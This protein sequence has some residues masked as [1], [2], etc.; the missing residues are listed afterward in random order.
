MKKSKQ[1]ISLLLAG[2][3]LGA[4][5]AQA[6]SP[7]LAEERLRK[8]L[9]EEGT[10]LAAEATT[11][12]RA[13][14]SSMPRLTIAPIQT[15]EPVQAAG[16]VATPSD[17]ILAAVPSP[18]AS[19]N[20]ETVSADAPKEDASTGPDRETEDLETTPAVIP[21][22][23]VS[24]KQDQETEEVETTPAVTPTEDVSTEPDQEAGAEE[25]TPVTPPPA[26]SMPPAESGEEDETTPAPTSSPE[27]TTT[28]T[29]SPDGEEGGAVPVP[30]PTETADVEP[31]P[32]ASGEVTDI[33]ALPEEEQGELMAPPMAVMSLDAE[34]E[35]RME[36]A[37]IGF[38]YEVY[39]ADK[40]NADGSPKKASTWQ[41]G[42][43]ELAVEKETEIDRGYLHQ[44]S[45]M[46]KNP[47]DG[48]DVKTYWALGDNGKY[49]Y[50]DAY[51]FYD[52]Q[53]TN[54]REVAENWLGRIPDY[55]F[56]SWYISGWAPLGNFE[57]FYLMDN[58]RVTWGYPIENKSIM[59][60]LSY[61]SWEGNP[62]YRL[63]PDG[64]SP[65]DMEKAKGT[66]VHD[67]PRQDEL[68][69][70]LDEQV[71]NN[72]SKYYYSNWWPSG[73][74]IYAI[75]IIA[76]WKL[77]DD[78]TLVDKAFVNGDSDDQKYTENTGLFTVGLDGGTTSTNLLASTL[79]TG[80][81]GEEGTG[82]TSLDYENGG[83]YYL[84][85]NS[86]VAGVDPVLLAT[87]AFRSQ[88]IE[89]GGVTIKA[90]QAG[91]SEYVDYT[92]DKDIL[93]DSRMENGKVTLYN[94][95]QYPM[96][97]KWTLGDEV[98]YI[99]L[100]RS[101]AGAEDKTTNYYNEIVVTVTAPD[102]ISTRTY[103]FFIQRLNDPWVAQ[104]PGNTPYGMIARDDVTDSN[105][106][107]NN[108]SLGLNAQEAKEEAR[109]RFKN[110]Y[111]G[112]KPYSFDEEKTNTFF[113]SD[114]VENNHSAYD[115]SLVYD[116][117]A[118]AGD[119]VD[120]DE[121]AIVVY[122][123]SSFVD[124]GFTIYDSQGEK[125]TIDPTDE[126]VK[127]SVVLRVSN[128]ASGGISLKE[129]KDDG[130]K[131]G[132]YVAGTK[133][134][135]TD[136]SDETTGVAFQIVQDA[137]GKDRI[138]LRGAQ[139][140]P[141]VYEIRYQFTDP[142][143]EWTY[144]ST[145]A[146]KFV[147]SEANNAATF[148]RTL[149]VLPILGDV[150]M[151]GA[152]TAADA[153]VLQRAINYNSG[154]SSVHDINF[155]NP[156]N[157]KVVDLFRLR[158]CDVNNDG[159]VDQ[160]D[161][162]MIRGADGGC[163]PLFV[164][165]SRCDDYFYIPLKTGLTEAEE[166][167][168][169]VRPEFSMGP[170]DAS[171]G[172]IE[173]EFLGLHTDEIT[174]DPTKLNNISAAGVSLQ[175]GD[176]F[177][178][179]VKVSDLENLPGGE[180]G[181]EKAAI[182]GGIASISLSIAYDSR[183]VE[184]AALSEEGDDIY[185]Q[186]INTVSRYNI[187]DDT[188]NT[189]M[190]YWPTYY[191]V[192]QAG[193]QMGQTY[194]THYSKTKIPGEAD[195]DRYIRQMTVAFRSG[196]NTF[197]VLYDTKAGASGD[198]YLLRVPFRLIEAPFEAEKL[199]ALELGLGMQDFNLFS[200]LI[201]ED[202]TLPQTSAAWSQ[203]S[204]GI[205]GGGTWN[206]AEEL[207][208][209]DGSARAIPLAPDTGEKTELVNQT[210]DGKTVYG[211]PYTYRNNDLR[212]Q[213]ADRIKIPKG[214]TYN[215]NDGLISGT[216]EE[217]GRFVFQVEGG[218]NNR[219]TCVI[220][221]EK[222]PLTLTAVGQTRYYGEPNGELDYQ[223]NTLE[224][225]ALD[226]QGGKNYDTVKNFQNNG[227]S[228]E[229]AK[230][231]GYVKPQLTTDAVQGS[232]VGTYSITVADAGNSGLDNYYFVYANGTLDENGKTVADTAT[233]ETSAASPLVVEKRPLMIEKLNDSAM[234]TVTV[235][236]DQPR[237]GFEGVAA[238][239]QEG[240]KQDFAPADLSVTAEYA[241]R[242]TGTPVY[243]KEEVTIS[244]TATLPEWDHNVPPYYDI[245]GA[246]AT[247]EA[248]ISDVVLTETVFNRNYQLIGLQTTT[249]NA[250]VKAN[251]VVKIEVEEPPKMVYTYNDKISFSLMTV[252]LT[253]DDG[254]KSR[255]VYSESSFADNGI[256]V[257]WVTSEEK[258]D[259]EAHRDEADRKVSDKDPMFASIHDGK[260]LCI[261]VKGYKD[262]KSSDITWYS[263]EAFKV[264]K[265][266]LTL[267]VKPLTVYYGE[268]E[269][270]ML[271]FTYNPAQLAPADYEA[272]KTALG[273][274]PDG[275]TSKELEVLTEYVAPVLTAWTGA[276]DVAGAKKVTRDTGVLWSG[277]SVRSY[278]IYIENKKD[279]DGKILSGTP[280]YSFRYVQGSVETT[281][282]GLG[283]LTI[284]PR[285]IV[286]NSVTLGEDS[287]AFLY[288]DTCNTVLKEM[289]YTDAE[290]GAYKAQ[291]VTLGGENPGADMADTFIAKQPEGGTYFIA[292]ETG[293]TPVLSSGL[294][295]D[296]IYTG[297][298]GKKDRVVVTYEA[299]YTRDN[300]SAAPPSTTYFDMNGQAAK[301]TN[302]TVRNLKLLPGEGDNANYVL[303]F[304]R[305]TD[306]TSS[307]PKENTALGLVK[308]R[309]ME[310]VSV[311][312]DPS[313]SGDYIYGQQLNLSGMTLA[314][315]YVQEGDN[316][317][318]ENR[319]VINRT[320]RYQDYGDG[321]DSFGLQGLMVYWLIDDDL[322]IPEDVTAKQLK[323]YLTDGKLE[324]VSLR[325][326]YPDVAKSGKK[327]VV[328]G[329]RYNGE[330]ARDVGH[331]LVW[332]AVSDSWNFQMKKK[333]LLL[334]VEEKNRFYGEA[335]GTF[336]ASY[337]FSA[338]AAP[339]QKALTD[340]SIAADAKGRLYVTAALD[341]AA[342]VPG[343]GSDAK[344]VSTFAT[345]LALEEL[346]KPYA[347]TTNLGVRFVTM[348]TQAK[349]VGTYTI[350]CKLSQETNLAN[351]DFAV[352]PAKLRVFRRPIV[353]NKICQQPVSNIYENT[354]ETQFPAYVEQKGQA[355]SSSGTTGFHTILP[356][357]NNG[358]YESDDPQVVAA[359]NSGM[360]HAM[361]LSGKAIYGEDTV[362]LNMTVVFPEVGSR[363]PNYNGGF[364]ALI[365]V[366]IKNLTLNGE[367]EKNY[368]LVYQ[369]NTD[370]SFNREPVDN[371]AQGQLDM[372]PITKI[373]VIQ[374]PKME[375]VYGEPL[376]LSGLKVRVTYRELE[377]LK[378]S[379]AL[380]EDLSYSELVGRLAVNYW[381]SPT[382]PG[383]ADLPIAK[384]PA[385]SGNHL[386][387]A[388]SH[389]D[390][391]LSHNGKYLVLYARTDESMGY[392]ADAVM[393]C[394]TT[395]SK[396]PPVQIKVEPL[397][398]TYTLQAEDKTYAQDGYASLT[399]A[400][401]S[402][403]LTNPYTATK[404]VTDAGGGTTTENDRDLI[405]V[406]T[407]V[408]YTDEELK[409][410]LNGKAN[411]GEAYTFSADGAPGAAGLTFNFYD[412]NVVY[413]DDTYTKNTPMAAKDWAAYWNSVSHEAK[414]SGSE[415]W[416]SYGDVAPMP[417][418][419]SGIQLAGPDKANYKLDSQVG[420][421][422]NADAAGGKDSVPFAAI[423]K[424]ARPVDQLTAAPQVS[425]DAH[426]NAVQ[427]TYDIGIGMVQ[428]AYAGDRYNSELHYEYGLESWDSTP[429]APGDPVQ[430]MQQWEDWSDLPYY[431]GEKMEADVPAGYEPTE[432]NPSSG[433]REELKGQAYPWEE[434]DTAFGTRTPLK[435][436]T[437]YWGMIRLAE[438][439]NYLA[440]EAVHAVRD[441]AGETAAA[442][443]AAAEM[444]ELVQSWVETKP[445]KDSDAPLLGPATA[446][447]TYKQ[448]FKLLSTE[449][450]TG[451]DN[452]K[453]PVDTLEAVWF[454]DLQKY[455]DEKLLDAVLRN[456]VT[457][458][459]YGYYWDQEQ[460]AELE[461]ETDGTEGLDL[462]QPLTVEVE[463]KDE[464]GATVKE[465]V[466]VNENDSAVIYVGTRSGGSSTSYPDS[467]DIAVGGVGG[468][469]EA[470][471]IEDDI[472]YCA[473]GDEVLTLKVDIKP[474]YAVQEGIVWTSSDPRVA[475]VDSK[476]R[477]ILMGVGRT[478]I[479]AT[480]RASGK[481][482]TITVVVSDPR[483]LSQ[484]LG[485]GWMAA[486]ELAQRG[487]NR[488]DFYFADAF[489][490]LDEDYMFHP[491]QHMTRGEL[492]SGMALLYLNSEEETENAEAAFP[493]LT[494]EETYL[495]AAERLSEAGIIE[496]VPGERWGLP[497]VLFGGEE[498]ATRAE[499]ATILCRM[500]G[501]EPVER[502]GGT[503]LFRDLRMETPEGERDHWASGYINA[504]A[505]AGAVQGTGDGY[506]NPDR[507][508][509]RAEAAA[510]LGRVL[511]S[512][513]YYNGREIVPMDVE[514]EHW[515]YGQ[516][517]RCV[518][519]VVPKKK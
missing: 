194:T 488:F 363:S 109:R 257:T 82:T 259:G 317:P 420:L 178:V 373:E 10:T 40:P 145:S 451:Q 365:G 507:K 449:E 368:Y 297:T 478:E 105:T 168:W 169:R 243:N 374:T 518:N 1:V 163:S 292:G 165:N 473:L 401:G 189:G 174:A 137:D 300:T 463:K 167:A 23:S 270:T 141:G 49:N 84:R 384:W 308:L 88:E 286:A 236:V 379:Y 158:V 283:D 244:F 99:P 447:K 437:V 37:Y 202:T 315:Q 403:T 148:R 304:D 327:L 103:T 360:V 352:T 5:L 53:V 498:T 190:Y 422:Q 87:E 210:N 32:A 119:N 121:D 41:D 268:F 322:E 83:T 470:P 305:L 285:P 307:K 127:R 240:G 311:S 375:Y 516:I 272:I 72:T 350:D 162:E 440:S 271:D 164:R 205:F 316:A 142:L 396:R 54:L 387:I 212:G 73:N 222:A 52:Y 28:P 266:V 377:D 372:R 135:I 324:E 402:I 252:I 62:D 319:G 166:A 331:V 362:G 3:M 475:V 232:D 125:V 251:P 284:Q 492:V 426:S 15:T 446:A 410:Y 412:A 128:A 472:I 497:G 115:R 474:S 345:S 282:Y 428:Q 184:P 460:S 330:D 313:R 152:V 448:S 433:E 411:D 390:P 112:G 366:T 514:P 196:S 199:E 288:D 175:E 146:D 332:A 338:L 318:T 16:E 459:Y 97:S 18:A 179:G 455:P 289:F 513:S 290:S 476:G 309:P 6:A 67:Q 195:W 432:S 215:S 94:N 42:F 98:G 326:G 477:L 131:K 370:D 245:E 371:T 450:K 200:V 359:V 208:Y 4:P 254:T 43:A 430:G 382:P 490:S 519:L 479:T 38:G 503:P 161:V 413:Y 485:E 335:N 221:V 294:T 183:Y 114:S 312:A 177:W 434:A 357:L 325:D 149:V 209:M 306:A 19:E 400:K 198:Q 262:G 391:D 45:F 58:R 81:I 407:N 511:L 93:N 185:S 60:P 321:S 233:D 436:D 392:E 140:L 500:M 230:L 34:E 515:A 218:D 408:T 247:K 31:S 253:F 143:S 466:M 484:G 409:T 25:T 211:E 117:N 425:V 17:N 349:D 416:D 348:G 471:V 465:E 51:L 438:T 124:P 150:D 68:A 487:E 220:T 219:T 224:I 104:N 122:Q 457:T 469:G 398:L 206:L 340:S 333:T 361:G 367:S 299:T 14:V 418:L 90:R 134:T 69:K 95:A 508:I 453:Y 110:G 24:T 39:K 275:S 86:D 295:G 397:D 383:K 380:T 405:Y 65:E 351:Y 172:T 263:K 341:E 48:G 260:Y 180:G 494:G 144:D 431:G 242:L 439:H 181:A 46:N 502:D 22:A 429:S 386:T 261:S 334:T 27:A 55:Q 130:G 414:T 385:T 277:G 64:T 424:A 102:G 216:P 356:D 337:L 132:Y 354:P 237:R 192:E 118:W 452:E 106:I 293:A 323:E 399:A 133:G 378:D 504:L 464:N 151:D 223:Y 496:G 258:K 281:D 77:S 30:T 267:R 129:L 512:G 2:Q 8:T 89:G 7:S 339:D 157:G 182:R 59:I 187:K 342:S 96:R 298:D 63:D 423:Q 287:K 111:G 56:D 393:V 458:R 197:R 419:V 505:E 358:K 91:S 406:T 207:V 241:G 188:G 231:A 499:A 213:P 269:D 26:T 36:E 255:I 506:F 47:Y 92:C 123:D 509:T 85:V 454:T 310:E 276:R 486:L 427:V 344:D 441:P 467:I 264:S 495:S 328:C 296:P 44:C 79:Y 153:E 139:V 480:T 193:S 239:Y 11:P 76:H 201:P 421:S 226:E 120:L 156:D 444:S 70:R 329:R 274:E 234:T 482:A 346:N 126:R 462:S 33:D 435:R 13:E 278:R 204:D 147:D 171:K 279:D 35:D 203:S 107:W 389:D 101:Q 228:A 113:P 461:F 9:L 12:S 214:L 176:V 336:Q 248:T 489:F 493:D 353:V 303:V 66:I 273:R 347:T 50:E 61:C 417:V 456:Q 445:E 280:D 80:L 217:V 517:L 29:T 170:A 483:G 443:Q 388:P 468:G 136:L 173:L 154:S 376:D 369:E 256:Q 191:T 246:S 20:G 250:I 355:S 320:L 415:G 227:S 21:S 225:K 100:T 229:L 302:V 481:T 381:D 395:D 57:E 78:A 108:N 155:L 159:L 510:M 301:T 249:A 75:P 442:Q 71:G 394:D 343:K 138:D 404:M 116:P 160:E 235:R 491:D 364:Q 265:Q 238:S 314:L 74:S 186:W 501:L 291:P